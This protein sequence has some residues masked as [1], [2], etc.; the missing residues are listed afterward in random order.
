MTTTPHADHYRDLAEKFTSRIEA[1]PADK[2]ENPSPCEGWTARD[3]VRHVIDTQREI[4]GV[5]DLELDEG[6]SVDTEPL[7]AWNTTRESMQRILD[8]PDLGGREYDGHFGRTTLAATVDGFH[9]FDLVVHGWDLARATGTD[10]T[11]PPADLQWVDSV[12]TSLGE[13]IRMSGV[14]GPAVSAPENADAQTRLLA[15]L[16]RAV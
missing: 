5:V 2:W 3:V 10:E 14:C 9:C 12:A 8:D 4:V 11:I 16:G 15:H 1:V 6:P 7:A 13:N